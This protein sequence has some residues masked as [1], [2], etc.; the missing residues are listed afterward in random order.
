M[1]V[2]CTAEATLTTQWLNSITPIQ[3]EILIKSS[4]HYVEA[5]LSMIAR[6]VNPSALYLGK[7]RWTAGQAQPLRLPPLWQ[8]NLQ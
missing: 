5:L 6:H 1:A 7:D 8:T 4:L 3:R 2:A